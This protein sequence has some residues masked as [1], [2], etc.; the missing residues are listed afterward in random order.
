MGGLHG[1]GLGH[2]GLAQGPSLACA[3]QCLELEAPHHSQ[4]EQLVRQHATSGT[5]YQCLRCHQSQNSQPV[6][7]LLRFSPHPGTVE[8]LVHA[9]MAL[10][11]SH[12]GFWIN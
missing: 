2:C 11:T 4:T 6:S 7:I 1:E 5:L 12:A 10:P 8:Q 9:G 3:H